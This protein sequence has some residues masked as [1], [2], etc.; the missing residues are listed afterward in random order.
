MEASRAPASARRPWRRRQRLGLAV[1]IVVGI[2][3]TAVLVMPGQE[4]LHARGPMNAGHED[5]DCGS[6]HLQAAG[7]VRQQIQAITRHSLGMREVAA[8]FGL[9]RVGN[10]VCLDCHERPNDRHPVFRFNEPRFAEARQAIAPQE[11]GSCHLEHTGR[12]VTLG[13][14][15]CRY[16]H[17]DLEMADDP[18]DVSH[19]ELVS[20]GRWLSCLGCHDFHGNHDRGTPE[21]LAAAL[22]P[23]EIQEY[24]NGAPSPYSDVKF[25]PAKKVR[26]EP[27]EAAR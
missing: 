26:D 23:A 7:T 3:V 10:R 12:R 19:A 4:S 17:E 27:E 14:G 5:L 20:E 6:C 8:D 1:G 21:T 13:Q 15:Y 25:Y 22:P 2:L 16:C 18:L 11:C 9:E 24:F